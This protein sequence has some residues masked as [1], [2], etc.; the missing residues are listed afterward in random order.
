M[1]KCSVDSGI[2]EKEQS[3]YGSPM[4]VDA[5]AAEEA[6][7]EQESGKEE[8]HKTSAVHDRLFSEEK[9]DQWTLEYCHAAAEGN[10]TA[11]R[12]AQNGRFVCTKTDIQ[13]IDCC[14]F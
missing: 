2:E 7:A 3:V 8:R 14:M 1:Q 5:K 11:E 4:A 13:A 6:V 12:K 10:E 9:Q